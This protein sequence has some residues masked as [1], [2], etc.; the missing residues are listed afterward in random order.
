M[1]RFSLFLTV[2]TV[3]FAAACGGGA[4][5]TSNRAKAPEA[6]N[7]SKPVSTSSATPTET[8][9]EYVAAAQS[10]DLAKLKQT[11]SKRSIETMEEL[12]VEEGSTLEETL[13]TTEPGIPPMFVNPEIRNEK[14]SGDKATI[15]VKQP[16]TG[17]WVVIPFVM[18]EGRWKLAIGEQF[19][20][21]MEKV[22]SVEDHLPVSTNANRAVK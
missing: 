18:E 21:E 2:L 13:K 4:A 1:I 16:D 10:R 17:E 11:A 22:P 19:D 14:I 9:K 5:N 8:L 15:E 3:I 20:E 12:L 7:S 6:S